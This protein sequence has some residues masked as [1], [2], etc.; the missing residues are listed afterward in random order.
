MLME[1]RG[2][3]GSPRPPLALSPAPAR[4]IRFLGEAQAPTDQSQNSPRAPI[5]CPLPQAD[6]LLP[7]GKFFP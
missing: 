4:P 2:G 5:Q 1:G 6:A 3:E 7:G